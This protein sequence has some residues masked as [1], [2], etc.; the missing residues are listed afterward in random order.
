[1]NGEAKT[2]YAPIM[3]SLV[4]FSAS[5]KAYSQDANLLAKAVQNPVANL[6]SVPFQNNVNFNV[7]PNNDTQN[8]LNIQPVIPFRVSPAWN[9]ITRTILPVIS[10]PDFGSGGSRTDG[11]GDIQLS[12]F[13]SPANV[14]KFVWGAGVVAQAPTATSVVLGAEKWGLGPTAVGLVNAGP[15][16][17]GALVNNVWDVGGKDSRRPVNQ[18]LIQ[19]FVNY[20]VPGRPGLYLSFSPI[21]TANWIADGNNTWTMPLG[22]GAGQVFKIGKQ[23]MNAQI[24]GYY[25]VVRPDA[26]GD[27]TLRLQLQFLFPK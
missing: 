20:N 23:A 18:M 13:L 6:I 17:Y 10:Q 1:M 11:L 8:V 14:G 25:N 21:I 2:F 3:I 22:M 12:T 19:P 27:F 4:L 15:W 7:G 24:H 26:A 16:L 5:A 9:V